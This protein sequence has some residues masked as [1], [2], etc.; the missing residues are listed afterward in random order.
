MHKTFSKDYVALCIY[1]VELCYQSLKK[2]AT[3]LLC[4]GSLFSVFSIKVSISENTHRP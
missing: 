3:L 2:Q 1:C 4:T